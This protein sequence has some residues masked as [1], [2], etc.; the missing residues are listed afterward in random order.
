MMFLSIAIKL[1]V[2]MI[3][4]IIV[5]R[6]LGKKE[7]AQVTPLDFVYA[8][9]LGG[10][11]EEGIYSSST[12][13]GHI[14]TALA[15]WTILIYIIE[16]TTQKFDNWRHLIKG[17]PTL[18]IENGKINMK[19]MKKHKLETEQVRELLRMQ[20]IFSIGQVNYAILENS[21]QLTVLER[22]GE[23][24]V[25]RQEFKEE[26][27]ENSLT[28]LLVEEGDINNPALKQAGKDRNWLLNELKKRNYP[29]SDI[30]F[31][32]WNPNQG[33]YVQLQ[34]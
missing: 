6:L 27:P 10:I 31:A 17:S 8:L 33:F 2:G 16:T 22:A 4:V 34:S 28:Y 26:F 13:V 3:G 18:I 21:G 14:L 23:E 7:M 19:A 12:N 5:T 32:E 29:L 9:I 11:I 30:Q 15:I 25:S 1:A 24:P 20:G